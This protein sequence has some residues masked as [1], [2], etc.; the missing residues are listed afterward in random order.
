VLLTRQSSVAFLP[1]QHQ[2]AA[3]TSLA[4]LQGLEARELNLKTFDQQPVLS[5][6]ARRFRYFGKLMRAIQPLEIRLAV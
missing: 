2:A 3:Q 5:V 4:S 6:Y 1:A